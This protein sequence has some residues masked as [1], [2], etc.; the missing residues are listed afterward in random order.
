MK[1]PVFSAIHSR[2]HTKPFLREEQQ[3][4]HRMLIFLQMQTPIIF[5]SCFFST[6]RSPSLYSTIAKTIKGVLN[7]KQQIHWYLIAS[8][9]QND[10]ARLRQA[11]PAL[12]HQLAHLSPVQYKQPHQLLDIPAK[13]VVQHKPNAFFKTM[14]PYNTE[15]LSK[16]QMSLYPNYFL[17]CLC[18]HLIQIREYARVHVCKMCWATIV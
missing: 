11:H 3:L 13:V 5:L 8:S 6:I 16:Y 9:Q 7:Q 14:L 1:A 17:G 18:L 2:M 15:G 12:D 10:L 4:S